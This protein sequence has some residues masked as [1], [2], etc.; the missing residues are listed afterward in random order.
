METTD[1]NEAVTIGHERIP[2]LIL[3]R[4]YFEGNAYALL[5]RVGTRS[6]RVRWTSAY[7]GC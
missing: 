4:E 2:T 6:W 1:V 7:T 5:E 3:R